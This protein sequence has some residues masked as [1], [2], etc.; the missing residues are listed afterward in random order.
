MTIDKKKDTFIIVRVAT[1]DKIAL[2][3]GAQLKGVG[4]SVFVREILEPYFND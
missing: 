1:E 4:L 3:E 2:E